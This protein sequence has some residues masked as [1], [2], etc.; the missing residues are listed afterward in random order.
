VLTQL[1]VTEFIHVR[2]YIVIT[3]QKILNFPDMETV[4]R[5]SAYQKHKKERKKNN[6]AYSVNN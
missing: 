6:T 4:T 3:S 2:D 1:W 5:I